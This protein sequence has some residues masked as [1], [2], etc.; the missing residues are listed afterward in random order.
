M[1]VI[2]AEY[3]QSLAGLDTHSL[4]D[5]LDG[6][7]LT[8]MAMGDRD[9]AYDP[10][11]RVILINSQTRPDRQRFTLAH[12]IGHALLL[13][14]DDLLSD[15]HDS[16]EGSRL[17]EVIET[18]CNVA[19]AAILMPEALTTELLTRFGPGGRALAELIRRAD[20]SASSAIYTLAERTNVPVI[21]AVCALS[22]V[23]DDPADG[24]GDSR[25]AGKAP[26]DRVLTVRVSSAAPSV[27]Y[28]LRPGTPIPD[29]HPVAVALATGIPSTED[30]YIPFRSGRRMP[31]HVDVFPEPYRVL[32]SFALPTRPSKG[33]V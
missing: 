4:M 23:E 13:G 15:L 14:D 33:E 28:S 31:A 3:A 16:F 9:G 10:E 27:K 11:H 5:G 32:V 22:R 2:A 6:V 19:A 29:D 18:L 30:S 25:S 12:E 8:F 24:A 17:E 1:R 26:T 21:Y 7:K 20:V